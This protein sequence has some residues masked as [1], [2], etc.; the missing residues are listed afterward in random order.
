MRGT[1]DMSEQRLVVGFAMGKVVTT[2][3]ANVI[4][5]AEQAALTYHEEFAAC[6]YPF[7]SEAGRLFVRIFR[8][9][10]KA[11]AIDLS[12]GAHTIGLVTR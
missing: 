4:K 6:P 11:N 8:V 12:V 3:M 9:T 5:E 1:T 7:D 2:A 10:K